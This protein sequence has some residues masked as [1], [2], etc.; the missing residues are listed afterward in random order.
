MNVKLSVEWLNAGNYPRGMF[1]TFVR[2]RR[3]GPT[4][5]LSRF[6]AMKL[7]I[8]EMPHAF[9]FFNLARRA[10]ICT[11]TWILWFTSSHTPPP[12][13]SKSRSN[14]LHSEEKMKLT[15][16]RNEKWVKNLL[17][18]TCYTATEKEINFVELFFLLRPISFRLRHRFISHRVLHSMLRCSNVGCLLHQFILN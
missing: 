7:I 17:S 12:S 14:R 11:K 4:W 2:C 6:N 5:G 16:I 1:P 3:D 9:E 13:K 10:L 8:V 15:I 18:P